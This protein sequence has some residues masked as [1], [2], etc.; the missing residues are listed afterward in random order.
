MFHESVRPSNPRSLQHRLDR[1]QQ[2][3]PLTT[4]EILE[5]VDPNRPLTDQERA[6][7]RKDTAAVWL[8]RLFVLG[9]IGGSIAAAIQQVA[10]MPR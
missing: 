5:L 10:N 4:E 2:Q 7:A 8:M 6:D 1:P 3:A 9:G